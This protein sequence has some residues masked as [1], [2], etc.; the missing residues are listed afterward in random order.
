MCSSEQEAAV[1]EEQSPH[2]SRALIRPHSPHPGN[3]APF[4]CWLVCCSHLRTSR[5]GLECIW[6]ALPPYIVYFLIYFQ[7]RIPCASERGFWYGVDMT[8]VYFLPTC[9]PGLKLVSIWPELTMWVLADYL[10]SCTHQCLWGPLV[11]LQGGSHWG[12]CMW[13]VCVHICVHGVCEL[14][15]AVHVYTHGHRSV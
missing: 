4:P 8:C 2:T 9:L 3:G 10:G 7:L 11:Q 13:V 1:Q 6:N 12:T 15:C 5:K 14:M